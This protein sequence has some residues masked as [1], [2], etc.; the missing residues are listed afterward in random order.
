M[1]SIPAS[2]KT[3]E[4]SVYVSRVLT[5]EGAEQVQIA[6]NRMKANDG[7]G[8][9]HMETITCDISTWLALIT[10]VDKLREAIRYHELSKP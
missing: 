4:Y 5:D 7:L 10:V 9:L 6:I 1:N 3:G 2:D 8:M